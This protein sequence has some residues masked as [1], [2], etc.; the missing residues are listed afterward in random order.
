MPAFDAKA[1]LVAALRV[2][3]VR[4]V[5]DL[6]ALPEEVRSQSHGGCARTPLNFIAE[7]ASLN[8]F[9]AEILERGDAKRLTDEEE[10]ALFASVDT[11]DKAV[12]MLD[13]SVSRLQAAYESLDEN[14]LGDMTDKPF[15]RPMQKFGPAS[16][17]INHM[18]YHDGQLNYIQTLLG[19]DKIHW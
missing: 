7:C 1:Y 12:T 11:T 8:N 15:G 2:Q 3:H 5:N 14:T 16:L 4:L 6:K 19:D 17:P 10:T 18:M 9:I 13:Q